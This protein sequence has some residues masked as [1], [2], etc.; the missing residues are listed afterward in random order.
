MRRC[1]ECLIS[2]LYLQNILAFLKFDKGRPWPVD[3]SWAH[4]AL[5]QIEAKNLEFTTQS[6][7]QRDHEITQ[8]SF[9]FFRIFLSK[10]VSVPV[11]L[12][13]QVNLVWDIPMEKTHAAD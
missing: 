5:D 10:V 7:G 12:N 9:W 13:I 11:Y 1:S 3:A 6:L 4:V 2:G 8:L